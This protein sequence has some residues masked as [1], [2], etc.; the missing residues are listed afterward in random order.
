M[1]TAEF[2]GL[3]T[4]YCLLLWELRFGIWDAEQEAAIKHEWSKYGLNAS[5]CHATWGLEN[6]QGGTGLNSSE[7]RTRL[8][9]S[10]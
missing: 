8:A 1:S 2:R 4:R 3:R 10:H 9:C 7:S 6:E 5:C